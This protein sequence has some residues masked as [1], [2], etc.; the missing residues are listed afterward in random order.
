MSNEEEATTVIGSGNA[1]GTTTLSGSGLMAMPSSIQSRAGSPIPVITAKKH[2]IVD[3]AR[4]AFD[5][6][7]VDQKIGTANPASANGVI[8]DYIAATTAK[9]FNPGEFTDA[10][11]ADQFRAT[12]RPRGGKAWTVNVSAILKPLFPKCLPEFIF[13]MDPDNRDSKFKATYRGET[14]VAPF[15]ASSSDVR[16]LHL[17]IPTTCLASR[18]EI[19]TAIEGKLESVG[20][21]L[22]PDEKDCHCIKPEIGKWHANFNIKNL[23]NGSVAENLYKLAQFEIRSIGI[24][25]YMSPQF[26]EALPQN[27]PKCYTWTKWDTCFCPEKTTKKDGYR[28]AQDGANQARRKR[29]MEAATSSD[30]TF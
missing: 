5:L 23:Q 9:F 13:V 7:L 28:R 3:G 20:M 2:E 17:F 27:C 21:T 29:R 15:A 30:A 6:Q 22:R 26:M 18:P 10:E 14:T 4:W 11:W 8:A 1:S 12:F 24:R 25:T 19:R 16:W